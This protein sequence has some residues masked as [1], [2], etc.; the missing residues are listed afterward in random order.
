MAEW[1][2]LEAEDGG[3]DGDGRLAIPESELVTKTKL[4]QQ[5]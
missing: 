4:S 5:K 2:E 1:S 3:D